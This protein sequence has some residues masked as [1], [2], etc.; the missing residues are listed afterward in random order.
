[1]PGYAE[2][3]AEVIKME[4]DPKIISYD[5]LLEVFFTM[6]D[7]TTLNRQGADTGTQ[8]RSIILYTS[9]DQGNRAEKAKLKI[10]NAITEI[11][12]V[13]KFYPAEDY[14]VN[15][16]ENNITNTYCQLVIS[17]KLA[18]LRKEFGKLIT[19]R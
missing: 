18:K 11:K 3:D 14:H 13:D 6:H 16:Y 5:T 17:P 7:P 10:E 9:K 15:Y 4:F 2:G 12:V 8:Y 19:D 1:M